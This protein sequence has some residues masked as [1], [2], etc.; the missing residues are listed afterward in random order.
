MYQVI[1]LQSIFTGSGDDSIFFNSSSYN[2]INAGDG[3]DV[4]SIASGVG[5]IDG[6]SGA[7]QIYFGWKVAATIQGSGSLS[8]D[9]SVWTIGED[10]ILGLTVNDSIV[11]AGDG[12]Y[13]N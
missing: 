9:G 2:T 5:L 4:I 8:Q 13:Y 7:D 1:S 6:G 12:Q 3:N 10:S 11:S